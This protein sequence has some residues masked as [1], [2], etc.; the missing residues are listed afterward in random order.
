VEI[1]GRTH[2]GLDPH[3]S[4]R[5]IVSFIEIRIPFGSILLVDFLTRVQD[6]IEVVGVRKLMA[7]S[8]SREKS[9]QYWQ[10]L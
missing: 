9:G 3:N 7:N 1:S 5:S 8:L 10:I 6:D 4:P 2:L